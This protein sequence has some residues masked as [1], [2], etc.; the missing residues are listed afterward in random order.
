MKIYKCNLAKAW[1]PQN[2]ASYSDSGL[3][4]KLEVGFYGERKSSN[5]HMKA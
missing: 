5:P 4:W 1:D 3:K 2:G